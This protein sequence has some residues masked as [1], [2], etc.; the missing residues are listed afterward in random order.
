MKGY[1]GY[2]MELTKQVEATLEAAALEARQSKHGQIGTAHLL[3]GI[4]TVVPERLAVKN[5]PEQLGA[6]IRERLGTGDSDCSNPELSLASTRLL[7]SAEVVYGDSSGETTGSTCDVRKLIYKLFDSA[8]DAETSAVPSNDVDFAAELLHQSVPNMP[9][10]RAY[11]QYELEK[12]MIAAMAR[13]DLNNRLKFLSTVL[14]ANRILGHLY[15]FR[16]EAELE[17]VL[18]H[19]SREMMRGRQSIDEN[20]LL[21]SS[22]RIDTER[23][24]TQLSVREETL[25]ELEKEIAQLGA[26]C[27]P[28]A[29][30]LDTGMSLLV[31]QKNNTQREIDK[32]REDMKFFRTAEQRHDTDCRIAESSHTEVARLVNLLRDAL[33]K[34]R[35]EQRKTLCDELK[36]LADGESQP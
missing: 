1:S 11:A 27:E 31:E 32:L 34:A 10:L 36:R 35:T 3:L 5:L 30:H 8:S 2:E 18:Q 23:V 12:D 9:I 22:A 29:V 15:L 6:L 28:E 33:D 26:I 21:A 4:L 16:P 24:R 20:A 19:Y 13:L 17:G 7:Q 25:K 14:T